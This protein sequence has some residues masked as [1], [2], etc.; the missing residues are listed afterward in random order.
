MECDVAEHDLATR[1]VRAA[2]GPDREFV[3]VPNPCDAAEQQ[4]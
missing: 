3:T 2:N 4:S 1:V